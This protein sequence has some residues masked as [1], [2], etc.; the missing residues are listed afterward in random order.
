VIDRARGFLYPFALRR[1]ALLHAAMG[2]RDESRTYWQKF[3]D[4]FTHADPEYQ[5][6]VT[7]ARAALAGLH[8]AAMRA[9]Q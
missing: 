3:I 9:P 5:H 1:L 7:E 2:H 4:T 6:Y 8:S